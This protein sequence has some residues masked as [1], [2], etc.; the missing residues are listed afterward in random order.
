M[1]KSVSLPVAIVVIL[2]LIAV[3]FAVIWKS[4]GGLHSEVTPEQQK[5]MMQHMTPPPSK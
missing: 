1:N 3:I 5:A 4:T 2:I